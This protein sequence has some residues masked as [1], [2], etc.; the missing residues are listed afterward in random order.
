MS[1][2]VIDGATSASPPATTRNGVDELFAGCT[3]EDEAAWAG[4]HRFVDV[5]GA[6]SVAFGRD[7]RWRRLR[8]P[9][10]TLAIAAPAL[11]VA[12]LALP[13]PPTHA[14]HRG[15]W[16]GAV[17]WRAFLGCL[18]AWLLLVSTCANSSPRSR[19]RRP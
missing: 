8:R 17:E 16:T 11:F 1:R 9:A 13:T 12:G 3:L 4:L 5:L 14:W 6:L 10:L 15:G 18:V 7:P 2:R 19:I